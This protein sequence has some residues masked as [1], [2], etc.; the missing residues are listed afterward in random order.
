MGGFFSSF[1]TGVWHGAFSLEIVAGELQ[2]SFTFIG[3][4]HL[5]AVVPAINPMLMNT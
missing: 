3:G 2:P 4:A 1:E 5:R